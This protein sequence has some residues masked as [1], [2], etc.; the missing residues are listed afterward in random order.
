MSEFLKMEHPQIV[1]VKFG[2]IPSS[3]L[4]IAD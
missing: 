4:D 3:G 1:P 2:E